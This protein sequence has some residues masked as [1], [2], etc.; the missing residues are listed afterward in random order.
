MGAEAQGSKGQVKANL[1][2]AILGQA[3][4][5]VSEER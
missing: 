2:D 4:T 5:R 1:V 3:D